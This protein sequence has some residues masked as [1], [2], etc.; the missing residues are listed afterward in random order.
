MPGRGTEDTGM[1]SLPEYDRLDA[2]DL[3]ALVERKEVS[4][5]DLV[6]A[7]I[8]RVEARNP[9]LN[10]VVGRS[11]ERAR[12]QAGAELPAGAFRGVPFLLK[13]LFAVDGG[14]CTSNGSRFFQGYAPQ[15]DSELVRRLKAA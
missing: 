9:R 11:Y 8:E 15:R 12:R 14:T 7:A 6:E 2:T 3:A 13:D 4:P 1:P 10:A 5:S